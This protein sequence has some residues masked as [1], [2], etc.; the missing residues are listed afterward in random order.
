[1]LVIPGEACSLSYEAYDRAEDV[2]PKAYLYDTTGTQITTKNLVHKANGF[3]SV[4]YTPDGEDPYIRVDII[5]YNESAR[6]TVAEVHP[7]K[8]DELTVKHL[9]GQAPAGG[10]GVL[11]AMPQDIDKLEKRIK[12]WLKPILEEIE[13]KIDKKSEFKVETDVVKIPKIEIP[14]VSFKYEKEAI[15]KAVGEIKII[16]NSDKL[17]QIMVEVKKRPIDITIPETDLTP[18][19]DYLKSIMTEVKLRPIKIPMPDIGQSDL[20]KIAIAIKDL[21]LPKDRTKEVLGEVRAM[22]KAIPKPEKPQEVNLQPII[23][24]LGQLMDIKKMIMELP[25]PK[26]N[27]DTIAIVEALHKVIVKYFVEMFEALKQVAPQLKDELNVKEKNLEL[28]LNDFINR[29]KLNNVKPN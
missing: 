14:K 28:G 3:Y 17:K 22:I 13:A 6:T 4:S 1:M 10:S 21:P 18:L 5:V 7:R 23:S 9:Y 27:E 24:Q 11:G 15:L 29:Y 20:L 19:T 12:K 16:D 8:T 26:D 25:K 2:F